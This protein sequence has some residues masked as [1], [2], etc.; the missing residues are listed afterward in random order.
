ME[1]FLRIIICNHEQTLERSFKM[2]QNQSD[3]SATGIIV[4]LLI[5]A[6]TAVVLYLFIAQDE[7]VLD[8]EAPG[9]SIEATESGDV[10]IEGNN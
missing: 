5:A 10:S 8:V 9:V 4:G 3:G 1:R 2:A 7:K 6:V